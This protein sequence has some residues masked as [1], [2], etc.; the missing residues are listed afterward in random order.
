MALVKKLT[1]SNRFW[2]LSLVG[3]MAIAGAMTGFLTRGDNSESEIA[4]EQFNVG[5]FRE[6]P[7]DLQRMVNRSQAIVRATIRPAGATKEEGPF[8]ARMPDGGTNSGSLP[9]PALPHTY[10][11]LDIAEVILDDGLVSEVAT[12]RL[13][14]TRDAYDLDPTKD[15]LLFL[16]RNPD[17]SSYGIWG[18][19][20]ILSVS[21]SGYVID[22]DD[23]RLEHIGEQMDT[24]RLASNVRQLVSSRVPVTEDRLDVS[25]L[26]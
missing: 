10:Y 16:G 12:L 20:G 9:S 26:D 1:K 8:D 6:T 17:N 14:G 18:D 22:V 5:V 24:D 15:Y 7:S 23:S 3:V 13:G 21:D 11:D 19:W 2:L 4:A 25:S